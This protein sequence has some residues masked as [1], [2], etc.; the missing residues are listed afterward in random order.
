MENVILQLTHDEAFELLDWL[1]EEVVTFSPTKP[2]SETPTLG[3]NTLLANIYDKL[4]A[5]VADM[6]IE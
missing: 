6:E 2:D 5:V 1:E 4:D 3:L